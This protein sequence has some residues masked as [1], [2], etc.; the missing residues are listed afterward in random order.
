MLVQ[1]ANLIRVYFI[2]NDNHTTHCE[3]RYAAAADL[4]ALLGLLPTLAGLIQPLT[5]A[6]C[7][8]ADLIVQHKETGPISPGT[9]MPIKRG[10]SMIFSTSAA[11][12]CIIRV[13]AVRDEFYLSSGPFAHIKLDIGNIDVFQL[14]DFIGTGTRDV[15][16][17][18]L[19]AN[20]IEAYIDGF[21][22]DF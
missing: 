1:L 14:A 8:G 7:I 2:D 12:D 11:N 19:F 17:C 5:N 4:D 13:P 6:V 9:S 18:D 16:A 20:D 3:I 21:R 15:A 10:A 22:E